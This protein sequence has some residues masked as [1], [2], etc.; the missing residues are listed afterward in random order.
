MYAGY[1]ADSEAQ[2]QV[3]HICAANAEGGLAKYSFLCPNGTIFNQEYFICDW[4][5]NV[6]CSEAEALAAERNAAIA[7]EREAADARL[8]EEAAAA[9][10]A[11]IDTYGAG[12]EEEEA[13]T[14]YGSPLDEAA[15]ESL[16]SYV[17][18]PSYSGRRRRF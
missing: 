10:E 3:F 13:E 8:A 16:P 17:N 18:Q 15:S 11:V 4:G 14:G 12:G 2:C 7:S 1:Y 5:F 6:D 9:D